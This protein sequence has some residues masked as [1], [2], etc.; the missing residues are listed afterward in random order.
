ML[1]FSIKN[2]LLMTSGLLLLSSFTYGAEYNNGYDEDEAFRQA[3]ALSAQ[4]DAYQPRG[5]N[6]L[7]EDEQLQIALALSMAEIQPQKRADIPKDPEVLKE[8][9][10]MTPPSQDLID[11]ARY[12]VARPYAIQNQLNSIFENTFQFIEMPFC[13]LAMF[14]ELNLPQDALDLEGL[15]G[16]ARADFERYCK[17]KEFNY[18]VALPLFSHFWS[19]I[20][21]NPCF[22]KFS[23]IYTNIFDIIQ[24]NKTK[25]DELLQN[26]GGPEGEVIFKGLIQNLGITDLHG[27]LMEEKERICTH[28]I[29]PL[30]RTPLEQ[31]L[32]EGPQI[33]TL[34]LI[35]GKQALNQ[36]KALELEEKKPEAIFRPVLDISILQFQQRLHKEFEERQK[37]GGDETVMAYGNIVAKYYHKDIETHIN[38]LWKQM[39]LPDVFG[40]KAANIEDIITLHNAVKGKEDLEHSDIQVAAIKSTLETSF[41]RHTSQP[42]TIYL[43]DKT[44]YDYLLMVSSQV[45]RFNHAIRQEN[46]DLANTLLGIF[47]DALIEQKD[48][49]QAGMTGRLLMV[50]KITLDMIID[51]Y[52]APIKK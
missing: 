22:D 24:T 33:D 35:Q 44:Q 20:I 16:Q 17:D 15:K 6:D 43:T 49:C 27:Q 1:N 36:P 3:L 13:A 9:K 39:N 37:E 2:S 11:L 21:K 10:I 45:F 19:G 26:A 38:G 47:F 52:K 8:V 28:F 34:L 5:N 48:K 46:K 30:K 42:M 18:D 51:Y 12:I 4:G 50:H 23:R 14:G 40:Q 29:A 32:A 7:T 41:K 31:L 25:I